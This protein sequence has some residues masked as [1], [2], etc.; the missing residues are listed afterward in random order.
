MSAVHCL[1]LGIEY[2]VPMAN[3]EADVDDC[4]V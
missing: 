2:I 1:R 4:T 3:L